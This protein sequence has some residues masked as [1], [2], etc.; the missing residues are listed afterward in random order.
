MPSNTNNDH[1]QDQLDPLDLLEERL[2]NPPKLWAPKGVPGDLDAGECIIDKT[3]RG[4]AEEKDFRSGD[5]GEYPVVVLV[6]RDKSRVR[7]PGFGTV[8]GNRLREVE[9][10]DAVGI[11]YLGTKPST[12]PG[13]KDFDNYDVVVLRDGRPPAPS[14]GPTPPPPVDDPPDETGSIRDVI[15]A[16]ATDEPY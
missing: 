16:T 2:D 7:V 5:Y 3:V 10:G 8:L 6:C 15:A 13:M 12:N 1:H 11:T 4:I 9:V 14:T